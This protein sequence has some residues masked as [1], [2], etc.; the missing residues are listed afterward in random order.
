MAFVLDASI[1]LCWAFDDEDQPM[2][3]LAL[4]R[5]RQEQAW[6]PGIWW[7]EVRNVLLMG[8]RRGRLTETHSLRF[9]HWLSRL[10]IHIDRDPDEALLQVH[11]RTHKLT[12]YD[13][14]YL[15]LAQ[16]EALPLA[17][18]DRGLRAAALASGVP[19]LGAG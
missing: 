14:A 8:E 11:A 7:F 10:E 3:T 13:A 2:A 17:T 15:E 1:V 12:I 16:R 6:A 5:L 4:E 9:L 19:L 18:L